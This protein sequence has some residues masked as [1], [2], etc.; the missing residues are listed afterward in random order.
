MSQHRI[1]NKN[2]DTL[3]GDCKICGEGITIR[4]VNG[5]RWGCSVGT[6]EIQRNAI[7]KARKLDKPY[8]KTRYYDL[9]ESKAAQLRQDNVCG[10]CGESDPAKL[11]V[12]HDHNTGEVRGV[13]CRRHNMGL[14]YFND[15]IAQLQQAI[16]YLQN[17]PLLY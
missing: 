3:T 16:D 14:G 15:S 7:S 9:T 1:S 12:D 13:L 8:T 17:P 11:H 2:L 5:R 10:M 6:T 4:W